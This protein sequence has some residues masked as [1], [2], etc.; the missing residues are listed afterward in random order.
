MLKEHRESYIANIRRSSVVAVSLRFH[1][2]HSHLLLNF[3]STRKANKFPDFFAPSVP[4]GAV[5]TS[6]PTWPA[7]S[8]HKDSREQ[9]GHKDG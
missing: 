4:L 3:A 7:F 8:V 5:C 2:M 1:R 6:N 9:Q